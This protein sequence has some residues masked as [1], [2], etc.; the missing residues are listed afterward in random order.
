MVGLHNL[1][2]STITILKGDLKKKV[3]TFAVFG[4]HGLAK[5]CIVFIYIHDYNNNKTI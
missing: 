5:K 2:K 1:G 3:S 4:L